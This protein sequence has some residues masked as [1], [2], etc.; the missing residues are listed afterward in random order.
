[1]ILL[2]RM[3]VSV[4]VMVGGRVEHDDSVVV[5]VNVNSSVEGCHGSETG[6]GVLDAAHCRRC[7]LYMSKNGSKVV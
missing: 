2:V 6:V 4:R 1:M 3:L 7:G 5:N